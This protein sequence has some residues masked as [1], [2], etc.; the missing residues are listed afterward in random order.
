MALTDGLSE[1]ADQEIVNGSDG[2]LNGTN[3]PNHNTAARDNLCRTTSRKICVR[4]G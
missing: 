3:L 2:L 4:A 1:K